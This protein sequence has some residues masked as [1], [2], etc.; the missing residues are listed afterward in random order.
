LFFHPVWVLKNPDTLHRG[1]L[2]LR[3]T[4]GYFAFSSETVSDFAYR[5]LMSSAFFAAWFRQLCCLFKKM[6]IRLFVLRL[7][8]LQVVLVIP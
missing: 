1:L 4:L 3:V 8:A 2:V 5:F 6:Q 7:Q